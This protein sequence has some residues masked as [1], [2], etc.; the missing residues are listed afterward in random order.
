VFIA[1][2]F[3]SN[4][5]G[6]VKLSA[7]VKANTYRLSFLALQYLIPIMCLIPAFLAAIL[8]VGMACRNKVFAAKQTYH[9][10]SPFDSP[11]LHGKRAVEI[12]AL[13]GATLFPMIFKLSLKS[14]IVLLCRKPLPSQ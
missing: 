12:T 7:A 11:F 9:L 2:I 14:L 5:I 1:A 8:L 3:L 10:D 13:S 4:P 6:S